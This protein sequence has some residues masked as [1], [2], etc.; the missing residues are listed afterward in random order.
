MRNGVRLLWPRSRSPV[1]KMRGI[2]SLLSFLPGLT[3]TLI[4]QQAP[5][6][7][8]MRLIIS[9]T[10][11]YGRIVTALK[12]EDIRLRE[13]GVPRSITALQ[14][15]EQL[16]LSI[17]VLIDNSLSTTGSSLT[18]GI[19]AKR[20]LSLLIRPG[21][22][23]VSVFSFG[24][25]ITLELGPTYDFTALVAAIDKASAT[26]EKSRSRTTAIY[27]AVVAG[28]NHLAASPGRRVI[29]LFTDGYEGS[30]RTS[31]QRTTESLQRLDVALHVLCS[32]TTELRGVAEQTGGSFS[33]PSAGITPTTD[34]DLRNMAREFTAQYVLTFTPALANPKQSFHKVQ[35]DGVPTELKKINFKHRQKF[36]VGPKLQIFGSKGVSGSDYSNPK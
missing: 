33:H 26:P 20:L 6:T 31:R 7:P 36:P 27:D 35:I 28:A 1:M 25:T 22:D 5:V 18:S 3:L 9:A 21:T 30:S 8:E 15:A 23:S 2:V 11:S 32:L 19:L 16:P 10:D 12:K 4:A 17:A 29:L 24:K 13:E 34:R 14:S